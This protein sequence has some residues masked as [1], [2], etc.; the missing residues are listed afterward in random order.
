MCFAPYISLTTFVIEFLLALYLFLKNPK[1]NL[2][3]IIAFLLLML[4]IYQL[5]EFL[6]CVTNAGIFTKLAMSVTAIMPP[7]SISYALIMWKKRIRYY[8]HLLIYSPVVF[9]ILM[10]V[11]LDYFNNSAI[12]STIFIQYPSLGLLGKF[13]GLYYITYIFAAIILFYLVSLRTKSKSERILLYLG[14][15]SMFIFT[16]PTFI[17]ILFI[18]AFYSQFPSV[19]CE[20]ALLLAIECIFILWYKDKRNLKY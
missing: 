3:R 2:N 7:L 5:N 10:F 9:F 20:F 6:I 18:P 17:F 8:W 1:D 19:L 14:M 11:L 13:Y 12:C 15:L 16:V 4:G